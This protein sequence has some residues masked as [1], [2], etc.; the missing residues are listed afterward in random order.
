MRFAWTPDFGYVRKYAVAETDRVIATVRHALS[1]LE[2]VGARIEE[3]DIPFEEP[4]W[5]A[6]QW[7]A[8]D[9]ALGANDVFHFNGPSREDMIVARA[10]RDRVWKQ[11]RRITD[12]YNFIVTPTILEVA[13]THTGWEQDG[14]SPDFSGIFVAMTAVANFL[15][16][17]AI[18]V[19]AGFVDGM[20]VA[21]QIIG[22]P[23]SEP[24]LFRVAQAFIDAQL[25]FGESK[26]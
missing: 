26:P 7:T 6:N 12:T 3:L 16:W 19:P 20:P 18:S 11:F 9:P 24:G 21:L 10:V 2:A 4:I 25:S 5:A 13:P 8:M 17:P 23:D 22:R 15:G 1:R 14:L